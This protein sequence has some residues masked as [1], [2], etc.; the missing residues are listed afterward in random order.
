MSQLRPM[1]AAD[2]E[3]VLALNAESVA[4]TGT[5]DLAA[6]RRLVAMA[7]AATVAGPKGLPAAFL[8]AFDETA[9]YD[10]PN[11]LWFR[12]RER[13]FAYVDRIVVGEAARGRGHARALYEDLFARAR[14]SGRRLVGCE[15]NVEP[16]NPVSHAFHAA[17]GF[18]G[19]EDARL[20]NG[21][22]VRYY[23]RAL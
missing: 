23:A 5:L 21:K 13:R 3:A 10:S 7:F 4:A 16:P 22:L 9:A 19:L 1:V 11:Y 18:E 15:V 20:P 17:L 14:S 6:L 12:A 8:L 2:F